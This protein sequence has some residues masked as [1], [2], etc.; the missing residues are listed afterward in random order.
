[1]S[2]LEDH[3][4][5]NHHLLQLCNRSTVDAPTIALV[6][7]KIFIYIEF[8]SGHSFQDSAVGEPP[9]KQTRYT[10]ISEKAI[11]SPSQPCCMLLTTL[12]PTQVPLPL[13]LK[14][15]TPMPSDMDVGWLVGCDEHVVDDGAQYPLVHSPFSRLRSSS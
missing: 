3:H 4:L 13:P 7:I 14:I 6:S 8:L 5:T 9:K 10:K 12:A 1:M 11:S 15:P 2:K